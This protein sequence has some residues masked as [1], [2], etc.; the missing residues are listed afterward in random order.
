MSSNQ[1]TTSIVCRYNPHGR[2]SKVS[3]ATTRPLIFSVGGELVI[4]KKSIF[5]LGDVIEWNSS[6]FGNSKSQSNNKN[7]S[8]PR[9]TRD[10]AL[11]K[12]AEK[13]DSPVITKQ[14]QRSNG[15][16]KR[17][18]SSEALDDVQDSGSSRVI[19]LKHAL[20]NV[21]GKS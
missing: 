19:K 21:K 18:A 17:K 13:F 4:I 8:Q 6:T 15:A 1:I 16:K 12:I 9:R 5:V 3:D 2:H 11:Q 14:N 20:N 10:E 7:Q